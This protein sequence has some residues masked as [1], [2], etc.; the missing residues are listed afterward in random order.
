M[1]NWEKYRKKP[2]VI[3]AFQWN[4]EITDLVS[5]YPQ[6]RFST[7]FESCTVCKALAK[8]HGII[9]TLEGVHIVCPNDWII[10]GIKG[11]C[12]P[13]KPDIF[14]KTYEKK[15]GYSIQD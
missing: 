2:I 7:G 9:D 10:K 14:Y 12:Y 3:D 15:K 5:R 13:I 4:G 11:T 8:E 1:V 6:E